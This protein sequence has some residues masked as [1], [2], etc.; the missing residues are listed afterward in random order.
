M[1]FQNKHFPNKLKS[2]ISS[3]L[4]RLIVLQHL[5]WQVVEE[6][7]PPTEFDKIKAIKRLALRLGGLKSAFS[8]NILKKEV[9]LLIFVILNFKPKI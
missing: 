3:T 6:R 5:P 4:T 7:N 9:Y 8:K 1:N 2:K